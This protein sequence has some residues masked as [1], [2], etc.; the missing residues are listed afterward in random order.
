MD[1]GEKRLTIGPQQHQGFVAQSI[2]VGRTNAGALVAVA[3]WA[4]ITVS[5]MTR[6]D[7]DLTRSPLGQL[8]NPSGRDR[9]KRQRPD[10]KQ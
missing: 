1:N 4:F 9:T 6:G 2:G 5:M 7:R 10:P 3:G 8:Q